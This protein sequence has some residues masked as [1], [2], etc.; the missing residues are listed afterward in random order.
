MH[1][2]Q[3]LY[4]KGEESCPVFFLL[5]VSSVLF[6]KKGQRVSLY[7]QVSPVVVDSVD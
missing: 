5:K 6:L 3:I 4:N 2:Y 1:I 7:V